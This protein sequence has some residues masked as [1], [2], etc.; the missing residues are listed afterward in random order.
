[1]DP[2]AVLLHH[3]NGGGMDT[4]K[5]VRIGLLNLLILAVLFAVGY[6]WPE[7]LAPLGLLVFP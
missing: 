1:M 6:L 3:N 2:A 5:I 4:T 7:V